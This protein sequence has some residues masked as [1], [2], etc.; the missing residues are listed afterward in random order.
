M[1]LGKVLSIVLDMGLSWLWSPQSACLQLT[2]FRCVEGRAASCEARVEGRTASREARVE[3][4]TASREVRVE[5]RAASREARVEGR[6][7][8]REVRVEGRTAS[9]EARVE[10]RTAS[11]EVRVEG[12]AAS[13]EVRALAFADQCSAPPQ[14]V[15]EPSAMVG[16]GLTSRRYLQQPRVECE[17]TWLTRSSPAQ[18]VRVCWVTRRERIALSVREGFSIS[19]SLSKATGWCANGVV[20]AQC[21]H[22]QVKS[23]EGC[24]FVRLRFVR[25]RFVRGDCTLMRD[26]KNEAVVTYI[27]ITAYVALQ[28]ETL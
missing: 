23:A 22:L 26:K 1:A 28:R 24:S 13:R 8:S 3:G 9:R 16:S 6:T 2:R 4:R 7:A 10:G 27:A 21:E 19:I 12:R 18:N 17:F 25:L 20:S 11:R 14:S 5:G 15:S